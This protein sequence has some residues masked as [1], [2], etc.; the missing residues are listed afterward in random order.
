MCVL[1]N[2]CIMQNDIIHME[3]V[4]EIFEV[5]EEDAV[6]NAELYRHRLLLGRV[7]R[8]RLCQEINNP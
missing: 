6:E 7:K 8:N 4:D 5:E 2:I 1:H 3:E